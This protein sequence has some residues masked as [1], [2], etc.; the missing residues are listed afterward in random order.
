MWYLRVKSWHHAWVTSTI[1]FFTVLFCGGYTCKTNED[2]CVCEI[3]D[4]GDFIWVYGAES[5]QACPGPT[6]WGWYKRLVGN[7][8]ALC[9]SASRWPPYTLILIFGSHTGPMSVREW[10]KLC[11][12][13]AVG[14]PYEPV[15]YPFIKLSEHGIRLKPL[16]LLWVSLL[17]WTHNHCSARP[18]S[19]WFC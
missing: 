14:P 8:G 16:C 15:L 3:P 17:A 11:P 1:V 9:C 5:W 2:R 6:G 4:L 7:Q 13:V 12:S 18:R 19:N 10:K